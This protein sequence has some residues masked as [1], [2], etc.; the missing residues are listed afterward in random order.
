MKGI[1]IAAYQIGIDFTKTDAKVVFIKATEGCTY[2]NPLLKLHYTQAKKAGLKVGFY[3]FL[4]SNNPLDEAKHFLKAIEGLQSDCKYVVDI[5]V[6]PL[7]AS[8]RTRQFAS[9]LI[10]KGKEPMIYS[11]YYFYKDNLSSLKDIP[12]WVAS[13]SKTKPNIQSVGWQYSDKGS[14]GGITVDLNEFNEGIFLKKVV[15][16]VVKPVINYVL[17][18]QQFLNSMGILDVGGHR[19]VEDG[20]IGKFTFSALDNLNKK[21]GGK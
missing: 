16:K 18:T 1:D 8:T 9:Y 12:L 4:R 3:H 14:I 11:G 10:S 19:L 13:Y 7:N 5:E 2:I 15:V 21:L 6:E 17:K 20:L